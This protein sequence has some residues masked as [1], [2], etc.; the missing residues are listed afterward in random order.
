MT[1]DPPA[2][3][4]V[5]LSDASSD[6]ST[7]FDLSKF[8]M[9]S[10]DK[11]GRQTTLRL[12]VPPSLLRTI[13]EIVAK[14]VVPEYRTAQDVLRD[15]LVVGLHMR[16]KQIDDP[17]FI[18]EIGMLKLAAEVETDLARMEN[19][20]VIVENLEKMAGRAD[21]TDTK[22][23]VKVRA[24]AALEQCKGEGNRRRLEALTR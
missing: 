1:V 14:R 13:Q 10:T 17:A 15:V 9:S 6:A 3:R 20:K 19:E 23:R 22:G 7:E 4:D 8:Y 2:D 12:H 5:F 11:K 24:L 16:V 21:D 18:H